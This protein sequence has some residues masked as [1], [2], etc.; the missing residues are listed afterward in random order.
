VK[1]VFV[2]TM[3]AAPWGGSEE[4][5]SQT[6]LRLHKEKHAVAVSVLYW[7][8]LSPRV[9]A[10]AERGIELRLRHPG[11]ISLP[12][13]VWRRVCRSQPK[14]YEWMRTMRPNLVIISQ[15]GNADGLDWM[16]FCGEENLPFVSI[17]QCNAEGFWPRDELSLKL[18]AAYQSAR[19]VFCISQ[20]NLEL[21]ERQVGALLPNAT[22]VR[23]PFNV[24]P[25]QPPPWPAENGT[26]NLACVARLDPAAKGQ[27]L[28]LEVLS[29]PQWRERAIEVNLYGN[30][31]C[32]RS[33][34]QLA[35]RLGLTA[36]HFRGHVDDVKEIWAKNHLLVLPSRYEGLPLALVEAM[37]CE[38]AALVTD[39]GG[40][41]DLC[42]DGETG[43][44]APAATVGILEQS[45]ERAWTLRHEWQARGKA[46]RAR[47]QQVIP[48]DPVGEFCGRLLE[49]TAG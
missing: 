25:H 15:G 22:V 46:A 29:H 19:K 39:V 44:V 49:C 14:D 47:V 27:D 6:A 37:W 35:E 26:W 16:T 4:L 17:V 43:F 24:S 8:A 18:A 31:P 42:A 10:L 12:A 48:R 3:P 1:F 7:P 38:R 30:G 36:V 21:L 28:L 11:S 23:N 32:E 34:R 45:L 5:W 20:S 2:S 9:I 13:R 41:A 40:S 33:L